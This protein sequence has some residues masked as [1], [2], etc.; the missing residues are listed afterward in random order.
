MP[1][2]E[3]SDRIAHVEARLAELESRVARP[4]APK[5]MRFRFSRRLAIVAIALAL[6][7]PAGVVLASHRFD[8]VP[9]SHQF[10]NSISAIAD[11]GIT[12]GC[13]SPAGQDNYCPNGL[14]TR[15][16]MAAFLS[17]LGALTPG[18]APK[19]N[20]AKLQG[21][22]PAVGM[23]ELVGTTTSASA[24]TIDSFTVS[25]PGP[26]TLYVQVAGDFF[27]NLDAGAATS[28]TAA[29]SW[30]ICDT[31]NASTSCGGT[32]QPTF[33]QDADDASGTNDTPGSLRARVVS[34]AGSGSRTFYLN[35]ARAASASELETWN[36]YATVLFLPGT[37]SDLDVN[38]GAVL[39]EESA[40]TQ[41]D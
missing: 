36:T 3:S 35:A 40:K 26:G 21:S 1:S 33:T 30:G 13:P 22:L 2:P 38:S 23:I 17:R 6:T 16:Q 11:A 12:T 27:H 19:V 18:S 20:A 25:V 34:V 9:T 29:Y 10:H 31:P 39:S 4:S 15:G 5:P 37:G 28:L 32:Y 7:L 24:D 8:D 14:V 41:D